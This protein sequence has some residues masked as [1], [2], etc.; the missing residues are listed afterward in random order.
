MTKLAPEWVR[1]S[2]PVIRSP[3]RY[4]WSTAP[5]YR[6]DRIIWVYNKHI[7]RI[8]WVYNKHIYRIIWVYNKHINRIIW[9]YNKHINRII[10]VYNKHINRIIWVYNKHINRIIWVYNK[11]INAL[12][13]Y[14]SEQLYLL[15]FI[16]LPLGPNNCSNMQFNYA[17]VDRYIM[18][19]SDKLE[20]LLLDFAY[21][22]WCLTQDVIFKH[23]IF[24]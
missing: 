14:I 6:T 22:T 5:A 17:L 4:R 21:I 3:A 16:L 8:I 11:H 12:P 19:C 7:N 2:D 15:L 10:W 18:N 23:S 20:L 9:V 13:H 24:F 1:T